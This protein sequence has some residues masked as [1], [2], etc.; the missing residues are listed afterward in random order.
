MTAVP[1]STCVLVALKRREA[2]NLVTY[3]NSRSAFGMGW[4]PVPNENRPR[5]EFNNGAIRCEDRRDE[6]G[7]A[8]G[9]KIE[10]KS[11]KCKSSSQEQTND[12]EMHGASKKTK[13]G[14]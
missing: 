14:K 9:M 6:R 12:S 2:F 1:A 4:W 3:N 13:R 5:R 8:I 7:E 11:K 10:I